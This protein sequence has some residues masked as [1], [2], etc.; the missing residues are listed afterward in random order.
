MWRKNF[1]WKMSS[2]LFGGGLAFLFQIALMRRLGPHDFGKWSLAIGWGGLFSVFVDYGFNPLVSRD[3]AR[4]PSE[5][6]QY[7][8]TILQGKLMLALGGAVLL[9]LIWFIHP[10]TAV[11]GTLLAAAFVYLCGLSLAESLQSM[12]YAIQRFR[13]GAFLSIVQKALPALVGFTALSL[14]WPQHHLFWGLAAASIVAVSGCYLYVLSSLTPAATATPQTMSS[15]LAAG[16]PLFL[17]N[18]FILIYFRVDTLMIGHYTSPDQAG[19]YSAAYRFFELSNVVPTA[20]IAA[21]IAPLS[22]DI[23]RDPQSPMFFSALKVF[24]LM[25]VI[26]MLC[27]DATAWLVPHR[28]LGPAYASAQPVLL[29]LSLTVLFY[30]PNFLLISMMVLLGYPGR[31]TIYAGLCAAGNIVVNMWAIPRYGAIAA[32]WT[33]L[34]TEALLFFLTLLSVLRL[35][36]SA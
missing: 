12:T 19:L 11:S 31:N 8:K 35:R 25:A 22:K 4:Q 21:W 36:K 20:L 30:F 28:L 6:R 16:L 14:M 9:S 2:L 3:V 27:L 13:T 5:A 33:T 15:L 26:G 29:V 7:L 34:G 18:L 32:A 23:E 10:P 24:A 17:Q 1:V